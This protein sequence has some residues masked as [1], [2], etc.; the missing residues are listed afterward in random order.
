[1]RGQSRHR[2]DNPTPEVVT[3]TMDALVAEGVSEQ[4][5]SC[6]LA[7]DVALLLRAK[8]PCSSVERL[9]NLFI[10][11]PSVVTKAIATCDVQPKLVGESTLAF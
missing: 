6:L 1:M 8:G 7:F 5:L 9:S 2:L 10:S 4:A 11:R 3:P